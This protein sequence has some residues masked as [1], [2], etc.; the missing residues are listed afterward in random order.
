[1]SGDAAAAAE[2]TDN[3]DEA[4]YEIRTGGELAGFVTYKRRP[5]RIAFQ[6]TEVDDRFEGKGIGS[7][8]IVHV[9]GAAREAGDEVVPLCPFVRAYIERHPEYVDLVPADIQE[10]M[11]METEASR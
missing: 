2:I 8:L 6:H 7:Q 1:M 10:Q 4:R 5:G 9:L 11:G 3:A